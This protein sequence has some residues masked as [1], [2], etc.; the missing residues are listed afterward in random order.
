[1]S[2]RLAVRA[3]MAIVLVAGATR[4]AGAVFDEPDAAG[5]VPSGKPGTASAGGLIEGLQWRGDDRTAITTGLVSNTA[6]LNDATMLFEAGFLPLQWSGSA[7]QRWGRNCA[8]CRTGAW[9]RLLRRR[10]GCR[11]AAC[12]PAL[13]SRTRDSQL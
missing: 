6:S 8:L 1:M 3:A 11:R 4:L 12:R 13:G 10:L 7:G 9:G 5:P 2:A